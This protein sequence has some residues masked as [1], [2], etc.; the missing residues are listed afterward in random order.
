MTYSFKFK[1]RVSHFKCVC[2]WSRA[3][4]LCITVTDHWWV[5]IDFVP[6]FKSR[7][8]YEAQHN[9]NDVVMSWLSLQQE[10]PLWQA[11]QAKHHCLKTCDTFCDAV[12]ILSVCTASWH[13]KACEVTQ[14]SVCRGD[15]A[16]VFIYNTWEGT[17][18]VNTCS[19]P[20]HT[21][22]QLKDT[23][24]RLKCLTADSLSVHLP[25]VCFMFAT[26]TY[27]FS[28]KQPQR[29]LSLFLILAEYENN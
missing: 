6:E 26:W 16:A 8:I 1:N 2:I 12:G 14:E 3:T 15:F 27:V 4:W 21:L 18:R 10:I 28:K 9:S 29:G 13:T 22:Q 7:W 19:V 11:L 25:P 20:S 17:W 23:Q 5:T 24:S